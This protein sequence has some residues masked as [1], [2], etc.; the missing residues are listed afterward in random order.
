L[1]HGFTTFLA[2]LWTGCEVRL[3]LTFM[4]VDTMG[5]NPLMHAI[6]EECSS[7]QPLYP[8]EIYHDGMGKSY[9]CD[10]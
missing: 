10:G 5:G 1:E 2:P 3:P 7:G 9:L 6:V 8:V 4:F